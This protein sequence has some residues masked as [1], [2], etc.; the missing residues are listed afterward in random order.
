MANLLSRSG[1]FVR[2]I[3]NEP[4]NKETQENIEDRIKQYAFM[5]IDDVPEKVSYGFSAYDDILNTQHFAQSSMITSTQASYVVLGFRVDTKKIPPAILKKEFRKSEEELSD[6]KFKEDR[7]SILTR[8]EK[9]ELRERVKIRLMREILPIPELYVVV[10]NMDTGIVLINTTSQSR[11]EM[12]EELFKRAFGVGLLRIDSTAFVDRFIPEHGE[13]V[14]DINVTDFVGTGYGLDDTGDILAQDFLVWL[15]YKATTNSFLGTKENNSIR[16][17]IGD[18]Y[19][20]QAVDG[21]F[22]ETVSINSAFNE[23]YYALCI[24]KKPIRGAFTI[25]TLDEEFSV[26]LGLD[27]SFRKLKTRKIEKDPDNDK[28]AE[29]ILK[30]SLIIECIEAIDAWYREFARI[31]FNGDLWKTETLAISTWILSNSDKSD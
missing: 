17:Y 28:I 19:V 20:L 22:E 7:I 21:D 2:Y 3:L 26:E 11:L 4:L 14:Y 29:L 25:A 5:S 16:V 10:W 8:Q 12:F 9:L 31:R 1:N 27:G 23:A 30:I 15:W 18:K 6:R 13:S 24:G